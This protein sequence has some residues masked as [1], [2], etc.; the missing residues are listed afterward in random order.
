MAIE[1]AVR[2]A[3]DKMVIEKAIRMFLGRYRI[4]QDTQ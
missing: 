2:N 3:L 4:T 1:P